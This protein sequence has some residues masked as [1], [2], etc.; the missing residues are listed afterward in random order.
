MSTTAPI[1]ASPAVS[2][3]DSFAGEI[4]PARIGA[5]YQLGLAVV[6]LS[7]VLLPLIYVGLIALAAWGVVLHLRYDIWLVH[8]AVGRNVIY[9][10][11]AYL[12]PVVAGFILLFFMVKPFFA[13]KARVPDPITLDPTREPLLFAFVRRICELVGAQSPSRIDVDCDINASASLQ[14]GILSRKLVLTIGLPLAS[15]LNMQQFAGV[16]AHEFGH[17]AQGAGL[18]LTYIIRRINFWFARVVYERDAWDIKLDEMARDTDFRLGIFLHAARGCVWLTRRILW[19]LMHAGHVISC[20]M[21]RQM[22]YD[23]DRYEAKLAGSD[24]FESTALRLR[25]LGVATQVAYDDVRQ[26]WASRR[27]P[28]NLPLLIDHKA[29]SLSREVTEKISAATS[30]QKTGWRDT[31]PC[32]SDRVQAVRRLNESGIFRRTEPAA[33]LF[34]DFA[35]L[36][37]VVTKHKYEKHFELEFTNENLMSAEEIL[38]E[39]AASTEADQ[40]IGRFFGAVNVSLAPALVDV[41]SPSV[42]DQEWSALENQWREARRTT[43]W[44]RADMEKQSN[45][46]N[47]LRQRKT[48]LTSAHRMT[49]A[50]F[51]LEPDKFG[52]PETAA[53]SGEQERAAQVA[54][55]R[56]E[57]ELAEARTGLEAFME[58]IRLRVTLALRLA[59]HSTEPGEANVLAELAPVHRQVSA[60]MAALHELASELP[61]F[62]LLAQNH[63]N[64]T[65]PGEVEQEMSKVAGEMQAVTSGIQG[66]LKP[67]AYPFPHAKGPLT[68][69]DYARPEGA[70]TSRWEQAFS[71]TNSHI[72]KLF[73]LNFRL[74]GRILALADAAEKKLNASPQNEEEAEEEKVDAKS[75]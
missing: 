41:E 32:D 23:A 26:S 8:D 46:W 20:F 10:L 50:G 58:A 1:P 25:L 49:R 22:E 69:A 5:L 17:F 2:P 73:A 65:N 72:E 59:G 39:S 55:N 43:K 4:V 37:R 60:E 31:H 27:L 14:R 67:L 9:G 13:A 38:R 75:P 64:H 57:V 74:I 19:A 34:S 51:R 71:E 62:V 29:A 12:G 18:R 56:V 44:L 66:R 3:L 42:E 70:A 35:E 11:I 45:R 54:L 33:Q 53:S 21:L 16:L 24:A 6:A 15:G 36:S 30:A 48:E 7:M 47:E 61:A 68:V 40:M 63:G 52:L 28:E